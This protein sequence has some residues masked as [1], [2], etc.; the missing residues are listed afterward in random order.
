MLTKGTQA[1]IKSD[2]VFHPTIKPERFQKT[3]L[4]IMILDK[5]I[6][7]YNLKSEKTFRV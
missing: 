4:M 7:F 1:K 3:P 6:I 2:A 5:K